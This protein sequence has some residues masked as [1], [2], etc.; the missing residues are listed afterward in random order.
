MNRGKREINI[1]LRRTYNEH[2]DAKRNI[3]WVKH[4]IVDTSNKY[5][6]YDTTMHTT[7]YYYNNNIGVDLGD[8]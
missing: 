6:R 7:K 2:E 3:I 8:T 1:L 5:D 4:K